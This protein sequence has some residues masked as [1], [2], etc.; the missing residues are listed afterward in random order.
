MAIMDS[1]VFFSDCLPV[2][3]PAELSEDTS[4]TL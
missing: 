4:E 1:G 2:A 3:K